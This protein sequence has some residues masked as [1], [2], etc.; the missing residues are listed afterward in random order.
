MSNDYAT[1]IRVTKETAETLRELSFDLRVHS[2]GQ[3]VER[4]I[5]EYQKA[6]SMEASA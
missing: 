1:T 3:V 5:E 2:I 6:H 4:L